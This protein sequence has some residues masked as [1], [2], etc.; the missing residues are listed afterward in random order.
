MESAFLHKELWVELWRRPGA[1]TEERRKMARA[2]LALEP[3]VPPGGY[4]YSNCNFA[5]AGQMAETVLGEPWEALMHKYVFAPLGM[6]SAGFGVPWSAEPGSD[7]WPHYGRGQAQKP[8]PMADYP[9]SIGP[10]G[11]I[12]VSMQDWALFVADHLAGA[13]GK[14]GK[15]LKAASYAR[16]HQGHGVVAKGPDSYALGWM[17]MQRPWAKGSEAGAEGLVLFHNGTNGS[18][19]T[20][21]WI[22]PEADFAVRVATNI[23]GQNVRQRFDQVVAAV[24]QDHVAHSKEGSE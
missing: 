20:N 17:R 6:K 13:R 12:H 19:L 18:W 15:L 4:R 16:L 22:A 1:P 10:A 3:S 9:P 7:P 21:L 5:M 23:G 2:I 8:G 11:T 14:N 24:V